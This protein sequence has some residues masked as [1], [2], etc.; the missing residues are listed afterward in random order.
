MAS[1]RCWEEM[2]SD[3]CFE[4]LGHAVEGVFWLEGVWQGGAGQ[5]IGFKYGEQAG[6]IGG[7]T[8]KAS[9][10]KLR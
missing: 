6:E 4:R 5:V 3:Q 9:T 8:W 1:G 10:A 7:V 2:E